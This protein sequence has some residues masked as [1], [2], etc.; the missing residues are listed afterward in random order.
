MKGSH[1][2]L[3]QCYT[4]N[5]YYI[6]LILLVVNFCNLKTLKSSMKVPIGTLVDEISDGDSLRDNKWLAVQLRT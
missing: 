3:L 5:T 6:L 1:W 2:K 4:S